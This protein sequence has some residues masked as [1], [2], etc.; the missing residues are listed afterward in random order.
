MSDQASPVPPPHLGAATRD[1]F[2][3]YAYVQSMTAP[4]NSTSSTLGFPPIQE[5]SIAHNTYGAYPDLPLSSSQ[6]DP[7]SPP[8]QRRQAQPTIGSPEYS[9]MNLD[10][11]SSL[12]GTPYHQ[13]TSTNPSILVSPASGDHSTFT[14][15]TDISDTCVTGS[16]PNIGP[17]YVPGASASPFNSLGAG[18]TPL[19]SSTPSTFDLSASPGLTQH[20]PA[21]PYTARPLTAESEGEQGLDLV[22]LFSRPPSAPYGNWAIEPPYS[23]GMP[24][25]PPPGGDLLTVPPSIEP[26]FTDPNAFGVH[27]TVLYRS[28]DRTPYAMGRKEVRF[29]NQKKVN[30]VDDMCKRFPEESDIG[31]L[32]KRICE[33]AWYHNGELEPTFGNGSEELTAGLAL[34]FEVGQSILLGFIGKEGVC[35]Y[36]G[37]MSPKRDR[38]IAHVREHLGLRPFV[39]MEEKCPCKELSM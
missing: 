13:Y 24:S 6:F 20:S 31:N 37:H 36:C 35:L 27:N 16:H 11:L 14:G 30:V 19:F 26:A 28:S 23:K 39:C 10:W 21:V 8:P 1:R 3:G 22:A 25:A 9:E 15:H 29:P 4:Q 5:H 17:V 33:T 2:P 32:L 18:L 7:L 34:G 38:I 12:V